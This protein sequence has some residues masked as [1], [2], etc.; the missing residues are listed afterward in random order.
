[1]RSFFSLRFLVLI[2]SFLTSNAILSLLDN[3]ALFAQNTTPFYSVE[4]RPYKG[5][6]LQLN[7]PHFR[8]IYPEGLDSI[9]YK[10]GRILEQQYPLAQSLT[11]SSLKNFPVLITNYSDLSNGYV[12]SWNFKSEIILAPIKGKAMNPR[13]GDWLE[14]VLSHELLHATHANIKG[15]FLLNSFG[16]FF[17]PDLTRSINFYPPVGI[18]EGLAVYHEGKNGLSSSHGGRGNYGYFRAKYWANLL[19]DSPWS[20]GDG[21]IP[22]E[23]HYPLNRHY[24]AGFFFT[25]WLQEAYGEQVFS[26]SFERH[27]NRFP[28]GLGF[29]LRG[30]TSDWPS[31]MAPIYRKWALDTY[32]TAHQGRK[33]T[34]IILTDYISPLTKEVDQRRPLWINPSKFLYVERKYHQE[35]GV[36]LF[37]IESHDARLIIEDFFVEDY[38]FAIDKTSNEL[39]YSAYKRGPYSFDEIYSYLYRVSYTE[40]GSKSTLIPGSKRMY[41]PAVDPHRKSLWALKNDKNSAQIYEYRNK[42]W[43][44]CSQ[45]NETRPVS[46]T[47]HPTKENTYAFLMQK[48]GFQGIWLVDAFADCSDII[49]ILDGVADIGFSNSSIIDVQW[50][51]MK[52]TLLLSVDNKDGVRIVE[53]DIETF[54][55]IVV[56][57]TEFAA[58]E[59]SYSEDGKLFSFVNE[60]NQKNIIAIVDSSRVAAN[61]FEWPTM[62]TIEIEKSSNSMLLGNDLL[63]SSANWTVDSYTGD[64]SWWSPRVILPKIIDHSGTLPSSLPDFLDYVNPITYNSDFSP[65]DF[66]ELEVGLLLQSTDVLQEKAYRFL[67]T[68]YRNNLWYQMSYST[69]KFWPGINFNFYRKPNFIYLSEEGSSVD[70][71]S[72]ER[73]WS[74]GVPLSYRFPSLTRFTSISITPRLYVEGSRYIDGSGSFLTDYVVQSKYGISSFLQL[75]VQQLTRDIQPRSGF[76]TFISGQ[77]TFQA[78]KCNEKTFQSSKC[79][80]I[81]NNTQYTYRLN[82]RY[83]IY[84]DQKMYFPI[85]KKKNISTLANAVVLK[86]SNNLLFSTNNIRSTG[87]YSPVFPES[88]YIGRFSTETII[89]IW[90]ADQGFFTVPSSLKTIYLKVFAHRMYDLA[91]KTNFGYPTRTSFGG[92]LNILFNISNIT[93]SAGFGWYYDVLEEKS[94]FFIGSF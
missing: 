27:Y 46:I 90:Y 89:P 51:P 52:S 87:F 45:F 17:G 85:W 69:K 79:S 13:G 15:R 39:I 81:L 91:N 57:D 56:L 94:G 92:E 78:S 83:A 84:A 37:D 29:A 9:A 88:S 2:A 67:G 34:P 71:I 4:Y 49:P 58:Y 47:V 86:Q 8:I 30:V 48:R 20:I 80:F 64:R 53:Y 41:A 21:L 65:L 72:D 60:Q 16:I 77:K 3:K 61:S 68:L 43:S 19:S 24:I 55:A 93:L 44:P 5:N 70:L 38:L 74:L 23:Y 28:L 18:H 33:K 12:Q 7:T 50:H 73:G 10:S 42:V 11:G 63:N 36:Y 54:Q 26:K 32:S 35:Q 82:N 62:N 59:A 75:R 25:E 6:W 14:T 31:K 1:M 22:T 66:S 76:I 40:A